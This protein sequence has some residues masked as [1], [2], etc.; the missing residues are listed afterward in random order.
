MA[1]T[2]SFTL[3]AP[4]SFFQSLLPEAAPYF[5][6]RTNSVSRRPKSP[7]STAAALITA[8]PMPKAISHGTISIV[9][10]VLRPAAF[11]ESM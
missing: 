10:N 11:C 9:V 2:F 3:N 8:T 1:T 5:G 6:V 4:A 7:S